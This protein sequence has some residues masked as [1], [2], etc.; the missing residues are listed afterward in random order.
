MR[1]RKSIG[2]VYALTL[3]LTISLAWLT[4]TISK[5]E[6]AH[7][8]ITVF[9]EDRI[10]H[11]SN[12]NIVDVLLRIPLQETVGHVEWNNSRLTLELVVAA[13]SGRP[14]TWFNDVK[15]LINVSF[16]E[17]NNVNR[18][19][20]R[21]VE[22][23]TYG[24][25]LLTAVDVRVTDEWLRDDLKSLDYANPVYDQTWRKRLRLSFTNTWENRFGPIQGY[26]VQTSHI[27]LNR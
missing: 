22:K 10:D 20:I 12:S 17:L 27:Q 14:E 26:S 25:R 9:K 16:A 2:T 8:N 7:Q 13:N 11:L 23:D 21:I 6:D 1:V 19:L 15:K 5:N 18:L 3:V 4:S 24:K